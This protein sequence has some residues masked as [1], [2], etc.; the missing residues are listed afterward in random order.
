MYKTR[1][2]LSNTGKPVFPTKT[3]VES[4][5]LKACLARRCYLTRQREIDSSSRRWCQTLS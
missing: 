1:T 5:K 2:A 4:L 3:S